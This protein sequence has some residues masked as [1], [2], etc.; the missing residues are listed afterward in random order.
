MTTRTK[1]RKRAA[2]G[3]STATNP[4][5]N[6]P[7]EQ[8]CKCCRSKVSLC[9]PLAIH[10][11]VMSCIGAWRRCAVVSRV[12][13]CAVMGTCLVAHEPAVF[14]LVVTT[15]RASRFS[16][17]PRRTFGREELRTKLCGNGLC[18]AMF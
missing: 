5:T 13:T 12:R 17:A 3:S 11:S 7:R 4:G 10:Y 16:T 6:S 9:G 18:T 8:S 14:C 1:K 15:Q 2:A